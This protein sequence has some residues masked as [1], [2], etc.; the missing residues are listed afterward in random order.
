MIED[1]DYMRQPSSRLGMTMTARLTILMVIVFALQCINDAYFHTNAEAWLA[2][3]Q[4]GLRHG[5][6]WQLITFQF[7]HGSVMHIVG[8][9]IAFWWLGHFVENVLGK[10]RF[11]VALFGCGAMGGLLQGV[12]MLLFPNA[13]GLGVVGAS[14]G[15]SGLLAIFALL[16][17]DTEVRFNFIF[18]IPAI[19]LLWIWGGVSL[20]FTLVP[21][22]RG[23][24]IAHAAHLGGILAGIAW[25][26]LGWHHDYVQ[27]PWERWLEWLKTP[28]SR[29]KAS[30]SNQSSTARGAGAFDAPPANE[31]STD[32]VDAVLDKISAHGINSLTARER[33]ILEA[34]RKRMAQR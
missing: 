14:A 21:S 19:V 26:K 27:L 9:L 17:K 8:N 29:P 23:G 10:K 28:R 30:N 4:D 33:A 15:V 7:L 5:W 12:L 13:F 18:P 34:A 24:G 11:L 31:Y 22:I 1:R 6:V 32:E 2:L 20:F 3:T 25:V 16:E